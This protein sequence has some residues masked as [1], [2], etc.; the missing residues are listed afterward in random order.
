MK[1]RELFMRCQKARIMS[2]LNSSVVGATL[3]AGEG[4]IVLAVYNNGRYVEPEHVHIPNTPA[5]M[6]WGLDGPAQYNQPRPPDGNKETEEHPE[7]EK[8]DGTDE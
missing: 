3:P 5:E 1:G 6:G 8:P 4:F 7:E 2:W